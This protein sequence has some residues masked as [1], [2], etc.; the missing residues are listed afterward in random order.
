MCPV[1]K[2]RRSLILVVSI[3][4]SLMSSMVPT[5]GAGVSRVRSITATG[6]AAEARE[7]FVFQVGI[8]KY[9]S[10]KVPKLD[11]CVQDVLD[12]KSLLIK[13]FNVPANHF[14]TLTD[15]QATHDAIIA[16]FRKQLIENARIHRDATVIFQY[17][18][19]GSQVKDR[20]GNKA[21]GVSSTL[22]PVNSRDIKGSYFDIV[23][24][25]IRELFEELSQYTSNITFIIDACHSGNPTR[26]AE[27]T[28]GIPDDDRPQPT[29]TT[30]RP[31]TRGGPQ[32]RGGELVA[33]LPRDQRYIAIAATLP[34]ELANEK[35]FP[36]I[37]KAN[38]ALTYYLLKALE[39]AKPETTYRQLMAEVANAVIA[40][41]PNQHPQ[42]EGDLGRAVFGG[43]ANREDPFIEI[44]DVKNDVITIKAGSAQGITSGTIVA[45]Y[46]ANALHLTGNNKKLATGTVTTVTPFTA[47]IKLNTTNAVPA[48]AKVVVISPDFG[49]IRTRVA[50]AKEA[51]TRGGN[52]TANTKTKLLSLLELSRSITLAD[53][54][55]LDVPN[56]R[57]VNWD[58]VVRQVKFS[59]WF[60]EPKQLTPEANGPA[61]PDRS[62][63]CIAGGDGTHPLFDFFVELDDPGAAE[64]I[65]AAL[66][67]LANQRSL[68]AISNDASELNGALKIRLLRVYGVFQDGKLKIE[69]EE[70]IDLPKDVQDYS[71]DQGELLRLEIENQS[72]TDL[73][74]TLFDISTDG[75]I[76]ILYPPA[77]AA[78]SLPKGAKVKPD[79]L[80]FRLGG[81]AG[82]ETYKLIA[83]TEKK[84]PSD[85]AFLQQSAVARN[86][87]ALSL[88]TLSDWTTAQVNLWISDKVK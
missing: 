57:G 61:S 3:L 29:A 14:L 53:E 66:E 49:S 78:V 40:A 47:T 12:M 62:V 87:G 54:L 71:F 34:Y 46:A 15:E 33:M 22:V 16:G 75:S 65:A 50:I 55:D 21:D 9:T 68:R 56:T 32:V 17:S 35:S 38:G 2:Q 83:S 84:G 37:P 18:G 76:Q 42:V 77:G 4:A 70:P 51:A 19:H 11:G 58:V 81:P 39:R 28:R 6:A 63:Y 26:G 88:A 36:E 60:H 80:I 73:Y 59:Q 74:L 45:V 25:E 64:K 10:P 79:S 24:D 1:H 48:Q 5:R 23:D 85:Y 13:K 69:R 30:K 44:Q 43:S 27:K 31:S 20:T 86:S 41:Y 82:Y 72:S 52:V 67:H 8:D 7:T